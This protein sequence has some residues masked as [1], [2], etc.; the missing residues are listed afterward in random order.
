MRPRASYSGRI[1]ESR[2]WRKASSLYG[3][4]TATS[5]MA[6][7]SAEVANI[8]YSVW[9]SGGTR[10]TLD[11]GATWNSVP[12]P[13]TAIASL[14]LDPHAA[15]SI[16]AYSVETFGAPPFGA[17]GSLPFVYRSDNGGTDWVRLSSP[18][19]A[20]PGLTVDGSTNPS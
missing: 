17:G 19:V 20:G 12:F 4:P 9:N 8:V 3:N 7:C 10:K 14:A 11:G 18:A 15:G 2:H 1:L 16:L 6:F 13:G 5:A